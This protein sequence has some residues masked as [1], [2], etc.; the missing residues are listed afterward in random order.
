MVVLD[1]IPGQE[2]RNAD[3]VLNARA[4]SKVNDLPLLAA[5]VDEALKPTNLAAASAAM[6]I[7]GRP[8]AAFTIADTL[9]LGM[10]GDRCVLCHASVHPKEDV[11]ECKAV[12][13]KM[14]VRCKM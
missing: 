11:T 3:V 4:G 8:A 6:R 13:C 14:C 1:P 7:L 10:L 2:T 9:L 12:R 5:T